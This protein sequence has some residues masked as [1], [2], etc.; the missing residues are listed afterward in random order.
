MTADQS[1][2]KPAKPLNV[3]QERFAELVAG[4]MT[5]TEAYIQAGYKVTEVVARTN[6]ARMLSNAG[7]KA[8]IAA[9]RKPVTRKTMLSRDRKRE[10][11]YQIAESSKEKAV[12]R[13]RAMEVDARIAGHFEP[14]RTEIEVGPKT[15]L[16]I[17]ERATQVAS[18][19]VSRYQSKE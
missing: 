10:I 14:D 5:G 7:I 9:L 11:L 3:R 1:N 6:A 13:I 8:K 4:G 16:S 12:D 18:S 2:P 19:L 17:K 15:L